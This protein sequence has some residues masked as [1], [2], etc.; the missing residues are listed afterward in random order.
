MVTAFV[1]AVGFVIGAITVQT[2]A[3]AAVI[4]FFVW[5]FI[6][7]FLMLRVR[8]PNCGTPLVVR[9]KLVGVPILS[10]FVNRYCQSCGYDLDKS[11]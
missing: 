4:A 2:Q 6:G 1:I 7:T 8:C 5:L 9:G 10:A 11:D 3:Q